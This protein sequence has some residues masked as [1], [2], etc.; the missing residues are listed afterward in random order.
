VALPPD[1]LVV[2]RAIGAHQEPMGPVVDWG[3][4]PTVSRFHGRQAELAQLSHYLVDDGCHVVAI[5]GMGGVGK[6]TLR[7]VWPD[8]SPA[9]S[10]V[11]SGARS[12]TRRRWTTY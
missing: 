4:A 6:T 7:P 5:L 10:T 3:D 9:I 8:R 11:F 1:A 12:S 2:S